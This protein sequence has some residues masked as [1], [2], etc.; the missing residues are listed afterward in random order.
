[1]ICEGIQWFHGYTTTQGHSLVH[2]IVALT[3][4]LIQILKLFLPNPQGLT[5]GEC[6]LLPLF[7][8]I[9]VLMNPLGHLERTGSFWVEL[10]SRGSSLSLSSGRLHTTLR[11]DT[12]DHSQVGGTTNLPSNS[13]MIRVFR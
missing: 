12:D 9:D 5:E 13:E 1:M 8:N 6:I 7:T 3:S 4:H 2:Y 10:T 11:T